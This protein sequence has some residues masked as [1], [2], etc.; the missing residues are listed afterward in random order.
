MCQYW[1]PSDWPLVNSG[2]YGPGGAGLFIAEATGLSPEGRITTECTGSGT[3]TSAGSSGAGRRLRQGSGARV[4]LQ[5]AHA[6]RMASE[7]RGGGSLPRRAGPSRYPREGGL[8]PGAYVRHQPPRPRYP[9]SARPRW[10]RRVGPGLRPG[11]RARG[12]SR[13][14]RREDPCGARVAESQLPA[15]LSNRR[16]DEHGDSLEN[17]TRLLLR[18][19]DTVRALIPDEMPPSFAFRPPTWLEGGWTA[20]ETAQV[21]AWAH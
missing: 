12:R 5:L 7:C 20:K 10:H 6:G 2:T 11:R 9:G 14:R 17:R 13:L 8:D 15:P 21:A 4:G 16:S 3:T 19:V 18:I 1:M